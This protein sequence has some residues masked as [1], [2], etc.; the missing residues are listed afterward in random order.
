MAGTFT[1]TGD[2]DLDNIVGVSDLML[3]IGA[4][5][6]TT[7]CCPYDLNGNGA[8]SVTDLIEMISAFGET[9]D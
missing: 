1:C 4:Y 8:V 5:G 7:G 3:F 6:C 9:C 2:F